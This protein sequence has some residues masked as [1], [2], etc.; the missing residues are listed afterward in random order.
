MVAEWLLG[1]SV[2]T[3]QAPFYKM[4][5]VPFLLNLAEWITET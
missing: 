1:Q 4:K 3:W 5:Y 2:G